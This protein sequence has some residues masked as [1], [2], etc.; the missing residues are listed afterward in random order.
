M[1][2]AGHDRNKNILNAPL[3]FA[4]GS[5]DANERNGSSLQEAFPP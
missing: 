1:Y 5:I 3:F 4:I 2:S